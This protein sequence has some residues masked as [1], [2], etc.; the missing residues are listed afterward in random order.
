MN[1]KITLASVALLSLTLV[2]CGAKNDAK[3]NTAKDNS[4][5]LEATNNAEA[6]DEA[7]AL[8][9]GTYTGKSS[10]DDFGGHMEVTITVADGKISNTE[11]KNLQKDGSEKGEDYGKEAGEEGHKTAQMTLEASQTYGQELTEK[12]SV[13]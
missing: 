5:K 10:E 12:G 6:T 9:D 3:E 7:M 4:T 11:V 2:G 13:E 1:K 8:K